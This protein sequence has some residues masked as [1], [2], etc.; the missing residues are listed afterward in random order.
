MA[1][2]F[3]ISHFKHLKKLLL[4]HGH[5]CYT[6]LANMIIY[7]FYKNVVSLKSA[8]I[9]PCCLDVL[10]IF[11]GTY[12]LSQAY[13]N[14]LFWYQFFCG[15]SGTTMID[16]WLMIFFNLFFTSVP[17]IMFGIMDKDLS[18]EML[19]GVPELYRTGQRSGVSHKTMYRIFRLICLFCFI[20]TCIFLGIQLYIFLGRHSGCLLS[21]PGVF[22]CSIPGKQTF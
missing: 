10:F 19:L 9:L 20:Y 21:E 12:L 13:V 1:S 6:R 4:V 22:F 14:L 16:Y 8:A 11:S 18:A 17:P 3:A 7:F 5:W 2:D 15:F